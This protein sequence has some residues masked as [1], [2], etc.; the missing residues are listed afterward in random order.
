MYYVHELFSSFNR[1]SVSGTSLPTWL[2]EP[3]PVLLRN[4]IRTDKN[5]IGVREVELTSAYPNYAQVRFPDGR[6]STVSLR[7]LA[8]CPRSPVES[9]ETEM[10]FVRTSDSMSDTVDSNV[11]VRGPV[12]DNRCCNETS[13]E[14]NLTSGPEGAAPSLRRSSRTNKGV[15]P[16]RYGEPISFE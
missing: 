14:G 7:D 10:R 13:T 9:N 2:T 12:N 5:D 8:P 3:G 16:I 15:P 1:R 11:A 6:E 4:F